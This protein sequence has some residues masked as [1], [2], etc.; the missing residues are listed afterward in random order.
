MSRALRGRVRVVPDKSMT[1]RG[2]LLA[3]LAE[4]TTTLG[5]PNRGADCRATLD[6]VAA[7]GVPARDEGISWRIEGGREKLRAATGPLDLGN[8]GT[9]LRLL[10]GLVAGLPFRTTLTGDPSLRSRPM[11]RVL[12]PL[13]RMGARIEAAEGSRA[14]LTIEGGGLRGIEH[15]SPVASAQVKSCL[16]LAGL[17]LERG[18]VRLR[19]PSPSRDHTERLLRRLGADLEKH[20]GTW[21]LTAP[22][23]LRARDWSVPGDLSAAAFFLVAASITPGSRIV[24]ERVGINPTRTG[25]LDALLRMGARIAI[26]PDPGGDDPEPTASLEVTASPLRATTI[27]GAEIPRLIDEIPVLAVAAAVAEGTTHFRDAGELRVKESDRIRSTC[28]LLRALGVEVEEGPDS[29][30]VRGRGWLD[31]GRVESRGDH[32]V[33]MAALVAGCA[34][35]AP[36][37]VDSL[38]AI[39]T[40]DPGFPARLE[41]L[42]G[43]EA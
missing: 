36:V 6:A 39:A 8:S 10:A 13:R 7:L 43:G 4:G 25:A 17:S 30:S 16:L 24:I 42:K 35:R 28:G 3:A 38:A 19:E 23:R 9:G 12:D 1:H 37:E 18:E 5:D 32:R 20:D 22:N 27:A 40:S 41:S 34:S 14:P 29:F 33:T 31:G 15:D 21:I 26:S 11:A 2:V